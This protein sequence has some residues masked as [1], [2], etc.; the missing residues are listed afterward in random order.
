[1]NEDTIIRYMPLAPGTKPWRW[2]A[3]ANLIILCSSLDP[4]GQEAAL[5]DLQAQWRRS[6]LRVV[7]DDEPTTDGTKGYPTVPFEWHATSLLA[8]ER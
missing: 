2:H 3:D 6:G 4:C 7:G 5:L 8:A 1:V